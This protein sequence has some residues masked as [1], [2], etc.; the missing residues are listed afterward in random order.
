MQNTIIKLA[1]TIQSFEQGCERCNRPEDKK[2]ASD[3]LSALAPLLAKT[4]LGQEILQDIS[5]IDRLFG[6]TWIVDVKP[7][8]E[9]FTNWDNFKQQYEEGTYK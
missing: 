8:E 7:F 5:A 4:V 9:A 6:N 1:E 3:Y 2:L